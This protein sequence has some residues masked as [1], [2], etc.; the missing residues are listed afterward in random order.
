MINALTNKL[1]LSTQANIDY[2]PS[3]RIG[4]CNKIHIGG[5][6]IDSI[7]L[8]AAS[9]VYITI[10][11]TD[12][13]A[14]YGQ[15]RADVAYSFSNYAYLYSG[16]LCEIDSV[17]IQNGRHIALLKIMN[18]E[19]TGYYE[20]PFEIHINNR[21]FYCP[22][23]KKLKIYKSILKNKLLFLKGFWKEKLFLPS[24]IK[25]I[26][27]MLYYRLLHKEIV[28]INLDEHIG[29]IVA[30]EPVSRIIKEKYPNDFLIW[31]TRYQ[32]LEIV[33]SNPSLDRT[34]GLTC[35][36]EW[37]LL[38]KLLL[39]SKIKV[40]DLH[41][42]QRECTSFR[43]SL[44]NPNHHNVTLNNYYNHGPILET[45]MLS[46]DLDPVDIAPVFH[47]STSAKT[48]LQIDEKY[49]V[50]H[51]TS[52]EV[53]REMN[54]K[55]WILVIDFLISKGFKVIEIGLKSKIKC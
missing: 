54:E 38:K 15:P 48:P 52:N 27:F 16:F 46:A 20:I 19:M 55:N 23:I 50:I 3:N 41:I 4:A 42:D 29:D 1:Q 5:W 30:C 22:I 26:L 49:I 9:T 32:Y 35:L 31:I 13:Q 8:K 37:I 44:Q 45:F 47:L 28:L 34:M 25:N 21:S 33:S 10:G 18:N 40:I 17:M 36:Y 39:T 51:T 43:I 7:A 14:D 6:A 53:D 24:I 2:A 11:D 12:F